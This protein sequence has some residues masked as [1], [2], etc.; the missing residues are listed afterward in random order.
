MVGAEDGGVP[1]QVVEVVHDDGHEQVDHDE[2]AEENEGDEVEVGGVAATGLLWV[3]KFP[4]CLIPA[5]ALLVTGPT[6]LAGQHDV[7]PGLSSGTS[8]KTQWQL[9]TIFKCYSHL[10]A[11][12]PCYIVVPLEMNEYDI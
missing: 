10:M 6:S 11:F 12:Q 2:A 1:G 5:V 3:E 7:R 8:S 9:W 4:C